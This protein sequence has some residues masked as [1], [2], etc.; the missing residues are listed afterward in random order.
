MI[1]SLSQLCLVDVTDHLNVQLASY[2]CSGLIFLTIGPVVALCIRAWCRDVYAPHTLALIDIVHH[3]I[4]SFIDQ[5]SAQSSSRYR[6]TP[7]VIPS[8]YLAPELV[9]LLVTSQ[10][11]DAAKYQLMVRLSL[12][13]SVQGQPVQAR[14]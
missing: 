7:S 6:T 14:V 8:N 10:L 1:R 3:R 12:R 4:Y 9:T 5:C 2:W 11:F 13:Y